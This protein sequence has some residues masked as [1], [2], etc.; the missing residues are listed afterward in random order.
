MQY[1]YC[2]C[3]YI[4]SLAT[5]LCYILRLFCVYLRQKC[6]SLQNLQPTFGIH[7]NG[8]NAEEGAK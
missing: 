5:L 1:N 7:S 3:C 8:R 2:T 4:N 6:S